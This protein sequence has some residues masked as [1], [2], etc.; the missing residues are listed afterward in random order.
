MNVGSTFVAPFLLALAVFQMCLEIGVEEGISCLN[1]N[2][3]H[4]QA[5]PKL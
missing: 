3:F 5:N 1:K 4:L 2:S